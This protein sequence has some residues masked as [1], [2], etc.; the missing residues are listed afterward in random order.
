MC[1]ITHPSYGRVAPLATK[2]IPL[3]HIDMA[4]FGDIRS[5]LQRPPSHEVWEDLTLSLS[6]FQGGTDNFRHTVLP[7]VSSALE[8]WPDHLRTVPA[9]WARQLLRGMQRFHLEALRLA[10]SLS[11]RELRRRLRYILPHSVKALLTHELLADLNLL[12]LRGS[13]SAPGMLLAMAPG[14][15]LRLRGLSLRSCEVNTSTLE[16]LI[17]AGWL[18][19]LTRLDLSWNDFTDR[20]I[21]ALTRTHVLR[22]CVRIELDGNYL[23]PESALALAHATDLHVRRL[24]CGWNSLTSRGVAILSEAPWFGE[25]ATLGLSNN[26]LDDEAVRAICAAN[27]AALR[28]LKLYNNDLTRKAVT[29]LLESPLIAQLTTLDVSANPIDALGERLL[30]DAARAH[31]GLSITIDRGDDLP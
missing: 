8:R 16:R 2:P 27:P 29:L 19:D 3:R 31:D 30:R 12:D 17:D 25:V 4:S 13:S 9:L 18:T 28:H 10:R 14:A 24:E 21:A 5:A 20:G 7:Y 6:A 26:H 15:P 1:Y 11:L 22:E 23:T